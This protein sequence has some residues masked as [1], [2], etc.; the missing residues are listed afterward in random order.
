MEILQDNRDKKSCYRLESSIKDSGR[1]QN[2]EKKLKILEA[3]ELRNVKALRELATS[4]GGLISDSIR[5]MACLSHFNNPQ[6]CC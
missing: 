1:V 6:N 2:K 4:E 3:C 5:R